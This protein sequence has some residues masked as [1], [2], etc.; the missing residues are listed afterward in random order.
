MP[1]TQT[2]PE[3]LFFLF[4]RNRP[5]T[6]ACETLIEAA[7]VQKIGKFTR[8]DKEKI[9]AEGFAWCEN[10]LQDIRETRSENRYCAIILHDGY[11]RDE[12]TPNSV[13]K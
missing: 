10:T 13:Y 4:T 7:F 3:L 11:I 8:L 5:G 1:M 12:E 9:V 2:V 6:S